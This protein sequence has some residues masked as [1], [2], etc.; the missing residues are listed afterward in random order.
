MNLLL[1]PVTRNL[2][3]VV[4][5]ADAAIWPFGGPLWG[6]KS[7]LGYGGPEG[8]K[9]LDDEPRSCRRNFYMILETALHRPV[10]DLDTIEKVRK[11]GLLL[12][13]GFV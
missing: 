5:W 6:L 8:W 1:D 4:D 2:R 7:V 10:S 9:W 12:R 13:Y 11:L 3:G